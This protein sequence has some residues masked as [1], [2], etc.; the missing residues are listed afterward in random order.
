M[1]VAVN[2]SAVQLAS[3]GIVDVVRAALRDSGLRPSQLTLEVTESV[4]VEDLEAVSARLV[5]LRTA[6]VLVAID[7]FGTGYSSLAYLRRLP[8]DTVKIDRSFIGD[9]A[10]GGSATTLVASIVELARSLGLDVVAEG[11]ET[12]QQ[13][14]LLRELNCTYAQGYLYAR[15]APAEEAA[16]A[17]DAHLL[18]APARDAELSRP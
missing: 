12:D 18:P 6:G 7:D 15:P 16:R 1:A 3:D 2:L 10:L 17:L 13:A 4:L 5:Q 9:L 8:V 14:Q 11:V